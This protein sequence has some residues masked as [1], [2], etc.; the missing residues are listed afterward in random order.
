[1][2]PTNSDDVKKGLAAMKSGDYN[3][4]RAAFEAAIAK[5][6]KQA[7]AHF[8]LAEMMEKTGDKAAAEAGYKRALEA[9]PDFPDA[10]LNL[11][12]VY[13]EGKKYDDAIVLAKKLLEKNQK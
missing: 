4:A 8:Y 9:Q 1:A 10:A 5:N 11:M 7:D 2:A 6:P 3:A 12:A 13:I